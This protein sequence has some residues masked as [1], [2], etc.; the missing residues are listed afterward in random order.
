LRA[1]DSAERLHAIKALGQRGK[2]ADVIVPALAGALRDEDAFVR[3]G[4][5]RGVGQT[6]RVSQ[7]GGPR[8]AGG[9]ARSE[10]RGPS[11][12]GQ[13]LETHRP[14]G[15]RRG[16]RGA[17]T[18]R[19]PAAHPPTARRDSRT[20]SKRRTNWLM[21]IRD[22][23]RDRPGAAGRRLRTTARWIWWA[24]RCVAGT[25]SH[26]SPSFRH[27]RTGRAVARPS[28]RPAGGRTANGPRRAR[29]G[30]PDRPAFGAASD[31][32]RARTR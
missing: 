22:S 14:R 32:A 9:D 10:R 16:R 2:E 17:L 23:L 30:R 13:G 26:A 7:G 11:G 29:T 8:P 27:S 1:K 21:L 4:R 6:R 28:P 25:D 31:R 12:G 5:R 15:G 18:P 24:K 20:C 3:R 19:R